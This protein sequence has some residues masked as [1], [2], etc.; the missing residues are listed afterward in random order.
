M[1]VPAALALGVPIDLHPLGHP[2]APRDDVLGHPRPEDTGRA[3]HLHVRRQFGHQRPVDARAH[4][5]KPLEPA[6]PRVERRGELPRVEDLG[7]R[8]GPRG[9]ARCG[10]DPHAHAPLGDADE[11]GVATVGVVDEDAR[12]R[13]RAGQPIATARHVVVRVTPSIEPISS[14]T[15][16]PMA[17][18]VVPSTT[19]MKSNGP[20]TASRLTTVD[21]P[22]L[23]WVSSFFTDL[24]LPA[25]VSMSTYARMRFPV[26][27]MHASLSA[28]AGRAPP[29][30]WMRTTRGAPRTSPPRRPLACPVR[31][32]GWTD[33]SAR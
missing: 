15:R 12:A 4:H 17:S 1:I 29:P 6:G 28:W 7:V 2:R 22:P 31:R 26:F 13:H 25:A 8:D 11:L 33:R 16:R 27:V 18:S 21:G 24:V 30:A 5:L 10:G 9:L 19:A 20:V 3:G 23:I 14:V 32:R